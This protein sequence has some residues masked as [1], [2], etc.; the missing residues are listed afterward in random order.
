MVTATRRLSL[1]AN[2]CV[3]LTAATGT[4]ATWLICMWIITHSC[5]RHDSCMWDMTPIR[6]WDMTHACETSHVRQDSFVCETRL[7]HMS[8]ND[9]VLLTAAT[10]TR[11]RWLIHMWDI[12]HSYVRHDSCTWDMIYLY[13]RHD[14]FTCPSTSA[15]CW[16]PLQA[17]VRHALFVGGTWL[18]RTRDTTHARGMTHQMCGTLLIHVCDITHSYVWHE[19]RRLAD[20]CLR[21]MCDMTHLLRCIYIAIKMQ[22]R[23]IR[24][25]QFEY[26]YTY[27]YTIKMTTTHIYVCNEVSCLG[28]VQ[29]L[30]MRWPPV[31]S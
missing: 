13:V 26:K 12:T 6:V 17:H 30:R 8:A 4:C 29:W 5:V 3:L 9:C 18:L 31:V 10:G 2:N 11:V 1:S 28:G 27:T 24:T 14:L 19:R 7:I 21:C 16:Q 20:S 25:Y 22:S 23:Y 15:S